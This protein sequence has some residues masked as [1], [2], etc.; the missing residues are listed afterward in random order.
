MASKKLKTSIM[1]PEDLLNEIRDAVVACSGPP[2]RLTLAAFTETALRRELK[3]LQK[4]H[5][6]GQPFPPNSGPLRTGRPLGA[7]TDD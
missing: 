7:R 6:G 2:L 3:R 1:L 5:N 4:E